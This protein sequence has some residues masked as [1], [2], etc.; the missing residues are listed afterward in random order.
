MNRRR[1]LY[2]L[3]AT[4]VIAGF[5][6]ETWYVRKIRKELEW[7]QYVAAINDGKNVEPEAGTI[8]FLKNGYSIQLETVKYVQDGLSLKGYVGNPYLITVSNLTLTFSAR[9]PFEEHKD[10]ESLYAY[11]NLVILPDAIGQAQSNI[12]PELKPGQRAAF[13][14]T[15]PNV[16]QTKG[17][18][19]LRVSFSGERY[20]YSLS[21]S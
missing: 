21:T 14:V 18:V 4:A 7:T 9:K 20:A 13:E 17:G 8:Q 5:A 19:S 2:T 3:I 12:I 16:K 6:V 11:G 15:V 10:D 1:I